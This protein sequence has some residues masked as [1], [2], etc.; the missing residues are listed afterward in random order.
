MCSKMCDVAVGTERGGRYSQYRVGGV[1]QARV[2]TF[3]TEWVV[4]KK[5]WDV[6]VGSERISCSKQGGVTVSREWVVC[7]RMWDVTGRVKWV[8][9]STI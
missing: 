9:C 2:V 1:Q 8:E 7:S 5:M 6:R 3:S 4:C